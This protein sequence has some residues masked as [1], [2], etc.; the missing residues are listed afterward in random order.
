[1]PIYTPAGSVLRQDRAWKVY[2]NRT[3]GF[4]I[5][6]PSRWVKTETYDG[7]G[8]A[9]TT[10]IKKHSPIPVGSMDVSALA[11]PGTQVRAAS[12]AL[13]SDF[14]L[15]L[16]GLKKFARAEQVEVLDRRTFT[17]GE[18]PS[19]FVKIRYLDPR[20]RRIWMD[21]IIFARRDGLSYR[22]ELETR[23][24]QLQRFEANF[25]QFVNSFQMDCASRTTSASTASTVAA[26]HPASQ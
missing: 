4:C 26:F 16:A 10:G 25:T 9:V 15:Q 2:L 18:S 6:Y 20:D 8:L 21:E 14:D 13:D 17:L 5:S 12:L 19:L 7:S 24:D 11:V 1:M 22:L 3:T 23:A